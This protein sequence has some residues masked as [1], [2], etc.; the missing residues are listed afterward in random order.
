MKTT[1]KKNNPLAES[2]KNN[3]KNF[4][5]FVCFRN[6]NQNALS[7]ILLIDDRMSADKSHEKANNEIETYDI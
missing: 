6:K 3:D 4:F 7:K 5:A 2:K 1:A